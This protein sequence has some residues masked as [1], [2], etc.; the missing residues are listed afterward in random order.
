MA[1]AADAEI[2]RNDKPIS[3]LETLFFAKNIKVQIENKKTNIDM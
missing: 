3:A 1:I 2:N